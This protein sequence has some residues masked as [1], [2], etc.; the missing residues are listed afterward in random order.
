VFDVLALDGIW[1]VEDFSGFSKSDTMFLDVFKRFL[2]VP[3]KPHLGTFHHCTS[4]ASS[5]VSGFVSWRSCADRAMVG[6][7]GRERNPSSVGVV[8]FIMQNLWQAD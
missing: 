1:V 6:K 2:I 4:V 8:F 3:F 7:S 5:R